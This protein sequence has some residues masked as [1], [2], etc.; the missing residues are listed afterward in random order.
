MK[1]KKKKQLPLLLL[2]LLF[3]TTA[4]YGTR[5]YFTDQASQNAGIKLT[6]G[7]L[8]LDSSSIKWIYNGVNNALGTEVAPDTKIISNPSNITNVQPGDVFTGTFKFENT[9]S[10]DQVVTITN[11]I[12]EKDLFKV[13]ISSPTIIKKNDSTGSPVNEPYT[14]ESGD[15]ITVDVT[16]SVS[17]EGN[18]NYAALGS[19]NSPTAIAFD[20]IEKS[21][22]VLAK[23]INDNN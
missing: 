10:L 17:T 8:N 5:A 22:T 15:F 14:L 2:A 13:E 12:T 23:Q 3:I 11:D 19:F 16:L 20:A 1:N 18:H 4:A 6:L 9:G 7:N 21:V